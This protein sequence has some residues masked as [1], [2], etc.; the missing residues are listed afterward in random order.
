MRLTSQ[1][2]QTSDSRS[3]RGSDFSDISD[4]SD[5][6]ASMTPNSERPRYP[7]K[8]SLIEP[9]KARTQFWL[10][11]EFGVNSGVNS[12]MVRFECQFEVKPSRRTHCCFGSNQ[13]LPLLLLLLLFPFTNFQ[14]TGDRRC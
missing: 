10:P 6:Q 7:R 11:A 9:Q 1:S 13:L 2:N 14:T 8:F 5:M 3:Y 4:I 12:G